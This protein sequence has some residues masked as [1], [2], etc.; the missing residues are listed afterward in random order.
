MKKDF[1]LPELSVFFPAYNEE[2]N[3]DSTVEQAVG[4]LKKIAPRWEV[5][6]VNDG[7]TDGTERVAKRL[8][9][10]YPGRVQM[11]THN[12]NRGYGAALRSGFYG[13]RYQWIT[14][15]DADGQFDFA[16][17][18]KLIRKQK[19][20]NADLVI[21]YYLKR[22][23]PFYRLIGSKI[24]QL[25]V[26]LLFGLKARDTDCAFKLVKKEVI[27]A[28]PRLESERGPFISSEFLIKAKKAGFKIVEEGV[29]HYPRKEG[30]ATGSS[31]KVVLSGFKD[32]L[33]FW[34]KLNFSRRK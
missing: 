28:I 34:F 2:K 1:L 12:P 22:K 16:D 20:T 18:R 17:V 4:V 7:S 9:K 23:V 15:T 10:K 32:L 6:I 33:Y 29:K 14:F 27:D 21:G 3:I 30:A 24:W 5:L 26:W 13:C 31:L 19:A 8:V 25:A 11:I